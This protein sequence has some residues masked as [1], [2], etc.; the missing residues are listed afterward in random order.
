MDLEGL[1]P[2]VMDVG[3]AATVTLTIVLMILRGWLV[4]KRTLD[5]LVEVHK[6]R[7][8]EWKGVAEQNVTRAAA[9]E[10]Q[11]STL[12]T[13]LSTQTQLLRSIKEEAARRRST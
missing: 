10:A 6:Q 11:A 4:P 13:E 1:P 2:W 8:D 5:S 12:A 7:A 9:A 3:P